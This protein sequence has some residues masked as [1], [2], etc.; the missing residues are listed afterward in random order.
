MIEGFSAKW[1]H[2]GRKGGGTCY[3]GLYREHPPERGPFQAGGISKGTLGI[4]RVEVWE[5]VGENVI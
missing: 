4:S 5:R 3:N 1:R 2:L